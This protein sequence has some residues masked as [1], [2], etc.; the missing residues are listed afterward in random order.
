MLYICFFMSKICQL[1][2]LRG[3]YMTTAHKNFMHPSIMGTYHLSVRCV[4]RSFLQGFDDYSGKD[5]SHRKFWVPNKTKELLQ[6]YAIEIVAYAGMDNH[7]HL[8]VRNRPDLLKD[9]SPIEIVARWLIIHPTK[10]MRKEKRNKPSNEELE[11]IL[12][13]YDVDELRSRLSDISWF[14]WD[15]NQYIAVKAN[16]EDKCKGAFF[17]SRF[18]SQNL[19]DDAAILTCMI[20]CDLNPIRAQIADSIETSV[21]TSGNIR[22]QAE[23]A[24]NNILKAK[25]LKE[26]KPNKKFNKR[27]EKEINI[28]K[29]IAKKVDWLSPL[30]KFD[31]KLKDKSRKPIL[32]ITTHNYLELLDFTGREY[33]KDKPGIIP[34]TIAPILA[35][36]GLSQKQWFERLKNYGKWYYR[37]LGPLIDL[38]DKLIAAKQRWFKG[39]NNWENPPN[40][41]PSTA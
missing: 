3:L 26:N 11:A 33:H 38:K 2:F 9:L 35:V 4:R 32:N 25:E 20:F 24:K 12:L 6:A 19:A 39:T 1:T 16:R 37:V 21:H 15:L 14:M 30:E 5:Y 7:Y 40:E 23:V 13:K 8:I 10:E 27:Q 29:S 28:Q 17:E 36:M 41:L 34:G 18:S 31:L 22:Y